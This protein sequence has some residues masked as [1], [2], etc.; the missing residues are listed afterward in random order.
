VNSSKEIIRL[1][2]NFG[3]QDVK[4][5]EDGVQIPQGL[6][7]VRI[8]FPEDSWDD[9]ALNEEGMGVWA[10]IRLQEI[11]AQMKKHT[12]GAIWEVGAG[13]GA[14]CIG[15]SKLGYEAIAVEPLYGGARYI[16]SQGL[17]S[18]GSTLDELKLPNKSIPAIGVFDVLE[19][20]E[21]PVP[22]LNEFSRVLDKNG[23][24]L[25]TV[26]AHQFLFS[27][28]D[29]S[30]GHFRRYSVSEL[31]SQLRAA[32][33]ELVSSRFLFSFLVPLAW[34]LRVLP[35]KIGLKSSATSRQSARTQ[36]RIAQFLSTVFRVLVAIEK[37]LRLPFGLSIL[38]VARP[39]VS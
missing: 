19:H 30:I 11:H 15:L 33:F 8:S 35:E 6:D 9:D 12:L 22:M 32:G 29:S 31:R 7:G 18:F 3:W 5:N 24:L 38:A 16:A 20:I 4:A 10:E 39:K 37:I 2:N 36:F 14:V 28:Y 1:A 13:N 17:V 34:L 27:E 26:P 23:L 25:I 21:D